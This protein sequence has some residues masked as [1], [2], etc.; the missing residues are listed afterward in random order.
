[1]KK[2]FGFIFLALITGCTSIQT[3]RSLIQEPELLK[4]YALPIVPPSIY[5]QNFEMICDMLISTD[6]TVERASFA[7]SSGDK[8]WDTLAI[9]SILKWKFTPPMYNEKPIKLLTRR[10]IKIQ[11]AEPQMMNLAEIVFSNLNQADSAYEALVAGE[12]FSKMVVKYSIGSSRINNGYLGS[13]NIQNYSKNISSAL[14]DLK[15][16]EFTKPLPYGQNFIIFKRLKNI[17]SVDK[18]ETIK[19]KENFFIESKSYVTL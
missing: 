5:R 15:E 9:A 7:K 3:Q 8:D 4:Q 11:F 2:L 14:S 13:T 19:N 17:E 18:K 6:G 1:M 16:D 10:K 12:E